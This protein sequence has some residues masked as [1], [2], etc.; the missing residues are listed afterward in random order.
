MV[1]VLEKSGSQLTRREREDQRNKK[2]KTGHEVKKESETRPSEQDLPHRCPRH[3]FNRAFTHG[4][5][6]RTFVR[7]FHFRL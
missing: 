3:T 1:F 5:A 7:T 6:D 2:E 4:Q